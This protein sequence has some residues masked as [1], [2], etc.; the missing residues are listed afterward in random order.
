MNDQEFN[1]SMA[2]ILSFH[3][4]PKTPL[5]V[6]N[7]KNYMASLYEAV[8]RMDAFTFERVC[9][10]LA[11]NMSRG[12]KPMPSQFW[13]VYHRLKSEENAGR[14][15]LCDSCKTTG[16]VYAHMVKAETGEEGDFCVP[17]PKCRQR[18]PLKDAEPMRGWTFQ[19]VP[20]T[21]HE[22]QLMAMLSKMGPKGARFV[23]DLADR[24]KVNFFDAVLSELVRKAG[25]EPPQ[26]NKVAEAAIAALKVIPAEEAPIDWAAEARKEAV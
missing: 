4:A 16:W 17:C 20:A 12:Q 15:D 9:K 21:S 8:G 18:H 13:A 1:S 3:N 26:Q 7:L 24:H 10:E 5:D 25:D 19:D 23:L 14:V 11:N 22:G 2:R 6:Q